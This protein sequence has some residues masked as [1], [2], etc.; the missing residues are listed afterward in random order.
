[1]DFYFL[2]SYSP[3]EKENILTPGLWSNVRDERAGERMCFCFV[4]VCDSANAK[5]IDNAPLKA[6]F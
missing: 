3:D 5:V 6:Q 4:F 2:C 1:M